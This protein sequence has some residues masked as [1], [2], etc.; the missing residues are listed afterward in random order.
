MK[1]LLRAV[2]TDT[3]RALD[4]RLRRR[5][6]RRIGAAQQLDAGGDVVVIAFG[7]AARTMVTAW[8]T[9]PLALAR[10]RGLVVTVAGDTTPLPPFEVV[11]GG[12][13]LPTAGSFRAAARALDLCRGVRPEDHVVFLVSGGGSAML[14]LPLDPSIDVDAW[15]TFYRALVGSGAGIDRVNRIRRRLSAVKGGRLAAAAAQAASQ[16]TI[17]VKDVPGPV[18]HIASGPSGHFAGETD[19][20]LTDLR[21]VGCLAALPE[22]L[23]TRVL[24]H[25]V[26]PLPVVPGPRSRFAWITVLD[27]RDLGGAAEQALRARG[28]HVESVGDVD[29]LPYERAAAA[30]VAR[31]DRLRR[32]H[33]GRPVALVTAG[34]LSVP[35]PPDPGIGGRNQQFVLACARRIRGRPITVLSCGS[36]G[37]DGSSPAAGA[38]ADGTTMARA[39]ALGL[40]VHDALR[41]CDAFPL[42]HALGDTVI[43]GPTGTNV[44]DL[45]MLVHAG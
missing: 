2:W 33:P 20:L 32:R 8:L 19:S 30:L 22:P 43:T 41:R 38:L 44:R 45:R 15:R 12:H 35:L 3:L 40:D 39:R 10:Q 31:L 18:E 34:E 37:V 25:E 16:T 21:A 7:K 11:A 14:E 29:D 1:D 17:V 23:R 27:E 42:L 28:L 26:P 36:D 6:P 5:M 9:A 4:E 24:R 13:P